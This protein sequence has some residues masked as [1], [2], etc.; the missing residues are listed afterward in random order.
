MRP[1]GSGRILAGMFGRTATAKAAKMVLLALVGSGLAFGCA[2]SPPPSA[3]SAGA[4][5]KEESRVSTIYDLEVKTIDGETTTLDRYRGK[6]LLVVN[7]A[8]RCGFT[9][10]YEALEALHRKHAKDGL[11]VLGFP[12]DQFGNQ[13]PGTEA[14]IKTFCATKYA[15]SFPMFAKIE[16]NGPAAHPLYQHLRAAQTGSFGKDT[17]GAERLYAHLEKT[18]PE[19]LGTDAVK[20]NF[21]KFLVDRRGQVVARFESTETPESFESQ[22]VAL[23][24]ER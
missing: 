23:L 11:A 17:E 9:P 8:S 18:M 22:I 15:V 6:V 14:E 5:Q 21:T 16:V 13:E 10:Q 4:P 7:V 19:V 20:W 2:S 12:C 3:Q 24:E 1:A